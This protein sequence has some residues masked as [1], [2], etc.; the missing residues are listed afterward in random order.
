MRIAQIAPLIEAVPPSLYGGTER[1][2]YYLTEQ[3]VRMGHDVTLF[4]SGDSRTSARLVPSVPKALRLDETVRDS[5]P[6]TLLHVARAFSSA[7][8]FD[9]MHSHVDYFTLPFVR[10][11][12]TPTLMTLHGRLDLPDIVPTFREY[13][14]VHL[15]SISN[16]QRRP[17]PFANWVATAYNGIDLTD[18]TFGTGRGGYLAFLGRISPE[19][20]VDT[21]IR[22]AEE[23]GL[24]LR[25]A[26]KVDPMDREYYETEI[27]PM[28]KSEHVEYIGEVAQT[29]KS[30]FLGNAYALLFPIRWP[31][32][33]GLTMIESMACG[34]P[35]IAMSCGSVK[36]IIVHEK[37][38]F[39]CSSF[40]E[41]VRAVDYV[42]AIDR[43]TCRQ[44]VQANFSAEVM[45][46][47]Y[48]SVYHRLVSR[49]LVACEE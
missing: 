39:I 41:M 45:A 24:P 2:V 4:A 38:G 15:V 11:V 47:T 43:H 34:T 17:F 10:Q 29:D 22:V 35:V 36:E 28:L 48:E 27:V 9:I 25:I 16:A 5:I 20:G 3:L 49:E 23:I 30:D 12:R 37:T 14:D 6:H 19:K 26:A 32:P 1:V 46:R 13:A 21:A 18:H 31:E 40:E 42:G 7:D 8:E 33:F 44:H